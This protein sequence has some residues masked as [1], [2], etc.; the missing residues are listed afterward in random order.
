MQQARKRRVEALWVYLKKVQ[1]V[2]DL[3]NWNPAYYQNYLTVLQQVAEAGVSTT[4]LPEEALCWHRAS[5][6]LAAEQL[7]WM[8]RR[9]E[10]GI[11][12][13]R[14]LYQARALYERSRSEYRKVLASLVEN[15]R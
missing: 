13:R 8:T 9:V 5:L 3:G 2:I 4:L 10:S 11:E 6:D 12:P 15:A 1:E 14:N 7:R